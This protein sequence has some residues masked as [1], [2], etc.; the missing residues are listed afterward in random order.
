M[1][2]S[3]VKGILG[4]GAIVLGS[5]LV[6]TGFVV[7]VRITNRMVIRFLQWLDT[8]LPQDDGNRVNGPLGVDDSCE[9][10]KK[11]NSNAHGE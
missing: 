2:S 7:L 3:L 5:Y 6:V 9:R 8:K 4:D 11:G 1:S 10:F